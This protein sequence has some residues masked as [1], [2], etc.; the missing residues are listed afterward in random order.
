MNNNV[1]RNLLY[2]VYIIFIWDN[3][4]VIGCIVNSVMQII[5]DFVIIVISIN[6]NNYINKCI[7]ESGNFVIFILGENLDLLIIGIFGF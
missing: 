4:R 1:F 6:Y 7:E 5:F 3:G 2:G